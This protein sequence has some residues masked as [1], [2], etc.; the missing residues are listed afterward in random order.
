MLRRL[1]LGSLLVLPL[2][3]FVFS[4]SFLT[5]TAQCKESVVG[6]WKLL[7][8]TTRTDGGDA[9]K[10]VLGQSP[11]G[12]LTYTADGRM[13]A[14]I[15][16]AGR[17]PLSIQLVAGSLSRSRSLATSALSMPL[18]AIGFPTYDGK[19]RAFAQVF[20]TV[21]GVNPLR[22]LDMVFYMV[23]DVEPTHF[24]YGGR[25]MY[26]AHFETFSGAFDQ[27]ARA[28]VFLP[29]DDRVTFTA[30]SSAL[31][32]G[33]TQIIKARRILDRWE[34]RSVIFNYIPRTNPPKLNILRDTSSSGFPSLERKRSILPVIPTDIGGE[35]T[36]GFPH[37]NVPNLVRDSPRNR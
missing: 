19:G 26:H 18:C 11:S 5:A 32:G 28:G 27:W 14:I 34:W 4:A 7:S 16:D 17:K 3:V 21:L 31:N 20:V 10:A 6:T 15:S 23:T 9:N 8:A 24:L 30:K 36:V 25:E 37:P 2:F 22:N 13:M 12:R 29:K 1:F 35:V 33:W